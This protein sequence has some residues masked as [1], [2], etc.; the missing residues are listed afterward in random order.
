MLLSQ[1]KAVEDL[2][3]Y[4]PLLA[5]IQR[6]SIDEYSEEYSDK[7]K[8]IHSSAT[9]AGIINDHTRHNISLHGDKLRFVEKNRMFLC[10]IDAAPDVYAIR[11][12][13]MNRYGQS[14]NIPTNQTTLFKSQEAIMDLSKSYNLEIGYSLD[15]F[16]ELVDII[17]AYPNGDNV[18]FWSYS[19]VD[20]INTSAHDDI[21]T[22]DNEEPRDVS[23]VKS[24]SKETKVSANESQ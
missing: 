9:K 10:I 3:E 20:K 15:E 23:R 17:L 18:P 6:Q 19:L 8:L 21:F 16:G 13:K 7:Q 12:K 5:D 22:S 4:L 2:K 24:K 1:E 14:A 11:F